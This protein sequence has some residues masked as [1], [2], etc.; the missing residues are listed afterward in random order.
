MEEWVNLHYLGFSD[1]SVN[2]F[3]EFRNDRSGRILR[4][5]R[6]QSGTCKIGMMPDNSNKQ[7]TL[8]VPNIT[9]GAFLPEPPNERFDTPINVDGNR[10]NNQ[11]DNL[12][13][14]PRWF[15]V[16]YH[17]QFHNDIRG[18][19]VPIIEL[20]SGE[21]FKTSWEAA[22][23]YGLIDRDILIATSNKTHVFP[24]GQKFEVFDKNMQFVL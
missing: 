14:R 21:K 24:T 7:Q 4:P 5:S 12:M 3:G 22:I 11:I 18:F 2:N 20:Y 8:S 23:K 6:N 10:T 16:K 9:A 15:A 13:W 17:Q 19:I 1:Y